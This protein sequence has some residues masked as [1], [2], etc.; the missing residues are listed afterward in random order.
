MTYRPRATAHDTPLG[1]QTSQQA[2]C[3][4]AA[5]RCP[6]VNEPATSNRPSRHRSVTTASKPRA[7]LQNSLSPATNRSPA[8]AIRTSLRQPAAPQLSQLS[9]PIQRPSPLSKHKR[10]PANEPPSQPAG[11]RFCYP[12]GALLWQNRISDTP[13]L[14]PSLGGRRQPTTG[15]SGAPPPASNHSCSAC[16]LGVK[17]NYALEN[18]DAPRDPSSDSDEDRSRSQ[19]QSRKCPPQ[20]CCCASSCHSPLYCCCRR[21]LCRPRLTAI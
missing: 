5:S 8:D 7:L 15:A 11:G 14:T 19:G 17:Q 13:A 20:C 10:Q 3:K 16:T 4:P 18:V 9:P 6:A 21:C 1:S 2:A 12:R